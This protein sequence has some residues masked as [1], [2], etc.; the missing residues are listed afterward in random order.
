MDSFSARMATEIDRLVLG[1]NRQ[2]GPRHGRVLGAIAA[3]A[4]LDSLK[5]IPHFADF[6]L[7]GPLKRRIAEAR[8]PYAPLGSV[9]ARLDVFVHLGLVTESGAGLE[10]TARFRPLLVAALAAREDV[11]ART[12]IDET[13]EEIDRPID[14]VV[15][16]IS[17]SHIVAAAHRN[18]E[19]AQNPALR[20]YDRLVTLR[21]AR[22]H[23]HVEAWKAAG[24]TAAE[25]ELLTALWRQETPPDEPAAM[26]QLEVRG[27]VA[28]GGL[29]ERG[30]SV[31]EQIEADTNR[32]AWSTWSVLDSAERS[33]LLEVLTRLPDV[34]TTGD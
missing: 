13:W 1:I 17:D 22:Q 12:W 31:R 24:M 5:L 6:W 10:A 2:V 3:E 33:A 26:G 19:P 21:C 16:A 9:G 15:D 4:G 23:D 7:S 29:T 14:A 28:D 25:M 18:L 11:V 27:L 32:R 34:S 8:L 20:L 30:R